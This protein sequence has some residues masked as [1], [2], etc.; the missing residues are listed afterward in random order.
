MATG[1][2][3]AWART[4]QR[5]FPQALLELG[6][7][8]FVRLAQRHAV[9]CGCDAHDRREGRPCATR[10]RL[11]ACGHS[12]AAERSK[13]RG[14]GRGEGRTLGKTK[15]LQLAGKRVALHVELGRVGEDKRDG[16]DGGL[17]VRV[18]PV[19]IGNELGDFGV[20]RGANG[21]R[22][23]AQR[24]WRLAGRPLGATGAAR[25]VPPPYVDVAAEHL[26]QHLHDEQLHAHGRLCAEASGRSRVP[27]RQAQA[28]AKNKIHGGGAYDL[29]HDVHLGQDPVRAVEVAA[30]LEFLV[31]A[32]DRRERERAMRRRVE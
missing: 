9:L 6:S 19:G 21:G 17:N 11:S 10:R 4:V 1:R 22:V 15:L 30:K 3:A 5:L 8:G 26:V 13:G 2:R 12:T 27:A 31:G 14:G 7:L 20:L 16:G 24:R 32:R 29:G 28:P 18:L 23:C 25:G